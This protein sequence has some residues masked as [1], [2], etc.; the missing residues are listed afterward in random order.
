MANKIG[1]K[2][3]KYVTVPLMTGTDGDASVRFV[4]TT[5]Q[6]RDDSAKY[7]ADPDFGA[8]LLE[9][10]YNENRLLANKKGL[11]KKKWCCSSCNTELNINSIKLQQIENELQY[12]N[13][14]VFIIQITIPAIE[15]SNCK[16][17]CGI[18]IKGSLQYHLNEAIM[19]AFS[20]QNIKP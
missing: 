4:N 10:I 11:F 20:S 13:L 7:F 2:N 12:K 9:K 16:K 15:C 8:W 19:H 17:V 1:M 6:E 5:F 3:K 18:D 14:P